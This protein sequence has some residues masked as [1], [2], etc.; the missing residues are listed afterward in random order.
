MKSPSRRE[1]AA[2][3]FLA[4]LFESELSI[5]EIQELLTDAATNPTFLNGL[6]TL[7][8]ATIDPLSGNGPRKAVLPWNDTA[9][10]E[11]SLYSTIQRLRLS[12][13][14]VIE[15]MAAVLPDAK[16][17]KEWNKNLPM[18][19][20]LDEFLHQASTKEAEGLLRLIDRRA[21][22]DAYLSGIIRRR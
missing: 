22:D 6:R 16:V 3:L 15:K 12:K 10:I 17:T 7:F 21:D 14:D 5:D 20:L 18:R 13:A 9:S 2:R 11:D 4:A 19:Q 1:R 8:H